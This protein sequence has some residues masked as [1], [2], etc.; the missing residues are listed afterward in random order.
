MIVILCPLGICE[1]KSDGDEVL[2]GT[3]VTEPFRQGGGKGLGAEP[4]K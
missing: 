4:G 2:M 3:A 1:N